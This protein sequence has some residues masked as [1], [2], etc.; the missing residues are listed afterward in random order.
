MIITLQDSL[1]WIYCYRLVLNLSCALKERINQWQC[2]ASP[3]MTIEWSTMKLHPTG[4][5]HD[6]SRDGTSDRPSCTYIMMS[7]SGDEMWTW[8]HPYTFLSWIAQSYCWASKMGL[9][10][11]AQ[12]CVGVLPSPHL[13]PRPWCACIRHNH[14]DSTII[15]INQIKFWT[16]GHARGVCV[17]VHFIV[18][19]PSSSFR[20]TQT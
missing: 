17:F 20:T 8:K 5:A 12:K 14:D 9:R 18:K 10:Y 13:I 2:F 4:A 6:R 7:W 19:Y 16:R 1:V 15:F 3:M 11:S